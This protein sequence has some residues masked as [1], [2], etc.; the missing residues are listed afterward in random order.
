MIKRSL[1]RV[2]INYAAKFPALSILG[3]RQS[4]KTTLVR[5]TFPH[6]NYASLEDPSIKSA[7]LEDPQKFLRDISND[8]G[9]ILDEVQNVPTLLSYLQI[10]ID[11]EEKPGYF[12]LTGS[13]N[14]LLNQAISQSLA[15]RVAVLTLLP[16]SIEELKNAHLLRPTLED[17]VWHGSYPRTFATKVTPNEWY[18]P[19]IQTYLERDVRQIKSVENLTT[20]QRFLGFCAGR[21]GQILNISSLANDCGINFATARGWLSILEMSYIIFLLQPQHKNFNKRLIKSPKIYFYDTGL[22]CSILDIKS[23]EEL[24][25]H[26]LRGGLV[27]SFVISELYKGYYNRGIRPSLSFWRDSQGHEID[28]IIERGPK[29]IPLEIKS[30]LTIND[31]FFTGVSYWNELAQTSPDDSYVIYGGDKNWHRSKAHVIAWSN[32]DDLINKKVL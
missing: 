6:H 28:C 12:V 2:L 4:G 3:P 32:I 29:L 17:I 16:L 7:A 20:F 19:Y 8:H 5:A 10:I 18:P 27:E 9:I 26:Y 21:I 22:A 23:A 31:S 13:H 30:A 1:E 11:R 14:L 15:G 24:K 25:F